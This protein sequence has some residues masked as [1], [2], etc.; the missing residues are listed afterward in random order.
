MSA[1]T[2]ILPV[3]F[4]TPAL[5]PSDVQLRVRWYMCTIIALSSLNYPDV[6]PHVY[7]HFSTHVLST[8]P[9]DDE[10]QRAVAQ[11]REGLIKSTGIVGAARTGNSM[12]ILG[13]CVPEALRDTGA[14]PRSAESEDV[15]RARGRRFW[16]NIY[17]RNKDFDPGAS[18]RASP[19]YAFV[20]RDVLYARIFSFDGI[21]DDLTTGYAIVA[22]LYGMDCPNQLQHHMKGM[23]INGATKQDL[24]ELRKQ[25]LGLAGILGVKLRYGAAP[26][27]EKP[28]IP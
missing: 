4:F 8:L 13:S 26:I 22:G 27:P 10:R 5:S 14:S 2:P 3:S 6:I 23:L 1:E 18:V 12:R 19:D 28:S 16:T 24:L 15:A 9:S 11:V 21:I 7:T 17:A 25:C 20:I